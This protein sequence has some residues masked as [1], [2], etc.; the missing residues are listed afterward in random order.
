[1]DVAFD[2]TAATVEHGRHGPRTHHCGP[3]AASTGQFITI[4]ASKLVFGPRAARRSASSIPG[5]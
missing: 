1:M 4:T 2:C 3:S 5:A